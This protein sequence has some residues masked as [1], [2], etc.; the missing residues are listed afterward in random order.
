MH[1]AALVRRAL[2]HPAQRG[3]QAGVLVGGDQLDPGQAALLQGAQEAAPEHLVLRI[4]DVAAQ[5]LPAPSSGDPGATTTTIEA[6]CPVR[7]TC[8]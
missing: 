6:T 7:R 8:S 3:D 1:P 5:H 2:E 4:A